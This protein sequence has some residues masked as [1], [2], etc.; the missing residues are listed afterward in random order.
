M[1]EIVTVEN[2]EYTINNKTLIKDIN[3]TIPTGS[4]VGIIGPNGSG[5]S[6]LLKT[7]YRSYKPTKG[8]IYLNGRKLEQLTDKTVAKEMAAVIQDHQTN[9]D[10]TVMEVMMSGQYAQYSFFS[11]DEK[12]SKQRCLEALQIVKMEECKEQSF[13]TLSGGEKQRVMIASALARNP[14]MIVLDE[15][16]NHLD[17][18][19]QYMIMELLSKQKT[20]I[21]MAIHDL[22]L[23]KRY[24]DYIYVLNHGKLIT[25]GLCHDVLTTTLIREVFHMETTICIDSNNQ[26]VIHYIGPI[27]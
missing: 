12:A 25:G 11:N 23:A 22:N 3:V 7:I 2:V 21:V 14:D 26:E 1:K 13:L 20:T 5:K 17:I 19:Y 24:C 4:F 18:S 15:P 6:T 9:F 10:L 8:C 16:T 27:E